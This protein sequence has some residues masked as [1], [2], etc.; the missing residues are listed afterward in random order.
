MR[1]PILGVDPGFRPIRLYR[2]PR[3]IKFLNKAVRT[4][5]SDPGRSL[6]KLAREK[7][8]LVATCTNERR[9]G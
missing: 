4:E 9:R 5:T 1:S 6:K 7:T 8:P 3:P 2:G